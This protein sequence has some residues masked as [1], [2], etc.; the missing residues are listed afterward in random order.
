MARL[1]RI[2]SFDSSAWI[3]R[4]R[5]RLSVAMRT[6]RALISS[7][8]AGLPGPRVEIEPQWRRQRRWCHR[9][10]VSGCTI[11]RTLFHR[12]QNRESATQKARSHGASRGFACQRA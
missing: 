7:E 5:Q 3:L 12:G 1:T 2:P 4:A 10:T 6:M 11:T 9:T 8:I